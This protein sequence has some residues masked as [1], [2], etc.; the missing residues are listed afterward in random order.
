MNKC[1]DIRVTELSGSQCPW[2][3]DI[4]SYDRNPDLYLEEQKV[5]EELIHPSSNFFM[6]LR[7]KILARLT[8]P[9]KDV[10]SFTG[11]KH[12]SQVRTS[13]SLFIAMATQ[14][15]S[16]WAWSS[17]DW[18]RV[19]EDAVENTRCG[20]LTIAYLL[21]GFRDV[22]KFRTFR[23]LHLA[24]SIFGSELVDQTV[25]VVTNEFVSLGFGRERIRKSLIVSLCELLLINGSPLIEDL[26]KE[27]LED[28]YTKL[29]VYNAQ[30]DAWAISE[31]L[32]SL[33]VIEEPIKNKKQIPTPLEDSPILEGV[34]SEWAR[35]C[36]KWYNTSTLAQSTRKGIYYGIL[37]MGRWLAQSHPDLTSPK[38][39]TR[40]TAAQAVAAIHYMKYGDYARGIESI[41]P[42]KIGC[43]L[44]SQAKAQYLNSL[45]TFFRDIQEWEWIPRRFDPR[46]S[47]AVSRDILSQKRSEPRVIQDDVWFKLLHAGLNLQP[48][49][50]KSSYV[51]KKPFYPIEMV[52]ALAVTWLFSGLRSDEIVR[53][54]VGCIRWQTDDIMVT[55]IEEILPKD[56]V[57]LIEVPVSKTSRSFTKP[58]DPLLGQAIAR[59][60]KKRPKQPPK[61][62]FKTSE[63]VEYLFTYRGRQIGKGYINGSLIPMLCKKAGIPERDTRGKITSHRARSTIATMLFNA[64]DPMSLFELQAW[65]GHNSPNATR[66][67]AQITLTKM[68]KSYSEAGYFSRALRTIDVLLDQDAIRVGAAASGQPWL[69]YDL[70][71]GYCTYDYFSQCP[72][73]M[74]CAKCDFYV[75]KEESQSQMLESKTNLIRLKQEISLTQ[76][77][78]IAV[79]E[80]IELMDKLIKKLSDIP[81]PAG[82]TPQELIQLRSEQGRL[83]TRNLDPLRDSDRG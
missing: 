22:Y 51:G 23:R 32:V 18:I 56:T 59:W 1:T 36:I 3:I 63:K 21:A 78:I 67:Y 43:P 49:E 2:V 54:R 33:S 55:G 41:S 40:E 34:S 5:L 35:Y 12:S 45:R 83:A 61:M 69:Y 6:P 64:K 47:F 70:G 46:R 16:F 9:V 7:R 31:V 57:C 50:I 62:D 14:R 66:S 76:E 79:D 30:G 20:L 15:R 80:G 44:T 28:Y 81:T 52:Q 75:P 19:I 26:S 11:I 8:K 73:R 10:F 72:H 13:K 38:Q 17:E 25:Q 42:K 82:P 68:A 27:V 71:H 39:W 60:E 24:S 37:A 58:V 65:L 4:S 48:D 77:E 74:A 53:L 29:Q